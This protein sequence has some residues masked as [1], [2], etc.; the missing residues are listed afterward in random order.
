MEK[1]LRLLLKE[2][3]FYSSCSSVKLERSLPPLTVE[4]NKSD[5]NSTVPI[6][7][8]LLIITLAAS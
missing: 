5:A 3:I 6:W 8:N 4:R 7:R 1:T 2:I